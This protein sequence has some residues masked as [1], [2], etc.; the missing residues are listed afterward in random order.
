[1]NNQ[2]AL[3]EMASPARF[4]LA[5]YRFIPLQFSLPALPGSVWGLDFIFTDGQNARRCCPS[6]LYTFPHL[7]CR[8]WAWLGIATTKCAEVS[9][10]LSRFTQTVSRCWCP[11]T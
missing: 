1:M 6:S 11:V 10:S 4:E 7:L 8:K 5:T 3:S 9:P 2:Q